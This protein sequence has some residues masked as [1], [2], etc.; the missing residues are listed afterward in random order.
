MPEGPDKDHFEPRWPLATA[1]V[2]LSIWI[3][4][5]SLPMWTGAFLGGPVSDQYGTGW[6]Y[7]HWAASQWK[8]LGHVPLWNPEIMGGLPFVGA[9]HGD[10]FYPTAWLRLVLPTTTAMNLGFVI[11]YIL[12]GLFVYVLLRLLSVSWTGSVVGGVTYQLSG[13]IASYASPGHDGKLF[14]TTL[15]PLALI[16]LV[17]AFRTRRHEG[18]GILALAVGLGALSP[19]HQMLYY[20]LV[21]SGLFALYLAFGD[22]DRP[23][24]KTGA[25]MLAGALAGVVVGF[26]V[27]M[28]QLIPF[29]AYLPFSPRAE[30]LGGY[31]TATSYAIPWSHVPELFVSGFVGYTGV[32][33]YWG[34]NGLKLH[35]E[36]LG[37]ASV[38]LACVG[39]MARERRRLVLW[40]GGIGLL[41]LLVALGGSTP[42]YRLWWGI[43]PFMKQ[44][45]A[46]G[47]A[48]YV[49]CLGVAAFAAF[50]VERLERGV[51]K[52]A[53]TV[54]MVAGAA[55][56]ALGLVGIVGAVAD[57]F[58]QGIE[59][60]TNRPVTAAVQAAQAGIR[61]GAV[62]SG[63]ALFAAGAVSRAWLKRTLSWQVAGL[64]LILASSADL[65][66]NARPF[67]R[68]TNDYEQL[69]RAD[70]VTERIL[71]ASPPFR[72]FDPPLPSV[73]H[74]ASLMAL[75]IP[76][77][78][79]HHGFELY[80]FDE[81]MGG[82]FR[83][84]NSLSPSLWDLYAI[85]FVILPAG[86]QG[87][88]SIPGFT[89]VLA[90]VPT[91][92][93]TPADLYRRDPRSPAPYARLVPAAVKVADEQ[94]I[95]A[96]VR[97]QVAVNRLILLAEDALHSPTPVDTI[98]P[99]LEAEVRFEHWEPGR[100]RMRIVPGARRDAYLLVS[101][102]WYPD[103]VAEVDGADAPVLR[104]NVS[105]IVV[106]VSAGATEVE[107]RFVS[108][109]YRAGKVVTGL[110]A[111]LVAM[112]LVLPPVL[113]RRNRA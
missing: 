25:L 34:P 15:L 101:E 87:L 14:V 72:V 17:L 38:G 88:D 11:H 76:Q 58:A 102:N 12:A 66:W 6:A 74:G 37:L 49:V 98:P 24:V 33:T 27:G 71:E 77:L 57:S 110:G 100:M 39:M 16:G 78:L 107:L 89:R 50:G 81:L 41:F 95:P 80:R 111:A 75:D 55:I 108:E 64:L 93:G 9:L 68:F 96:L 109:S 59:M 69:H 97:G 65:W 53:S 54:C 84:S 7:R 61:W 70:A 91:V 30:T 26:G 51:G 22:D 83:W 86:L 46:P 105:A 8:A 28:I 52:E 99:P 2:P 20:L 92:F 112:G 106:P 21:A 19:Q 13:V 23:P 62:A 63:V 45:R 73:Y 48:L 82:Q 47:M 43:M 79:G 32:N 44:V 40:L 85:E 94:A 35:S 5:L 10:I 29:F 42:F 90:G 36:Y 4:I 1:T 103:W 67:W 31:E 56:A 18:Y 113:R 60:R 104:G 3:I